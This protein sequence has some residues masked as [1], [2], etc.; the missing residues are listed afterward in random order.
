MRVTE[1]EL[2]IIYYQATL[3]AAGL[4]HKHS[5]KTF[6]Y[7]LPACKIFWDKGSTKIV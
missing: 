1:P 4:G 2:T 7:N 3:L 6:Y 5:H